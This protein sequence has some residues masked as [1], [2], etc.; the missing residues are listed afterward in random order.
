MRRHPLRNTLV[1]L[2]ILSVTLSFIAVL[3]ATGQE[4]SLIISKLQQLNGM[5]EGEHPCLQHKVNAVIHQIEAGAFHGAINKLQNDV[6]KSIIA[7][8]PNPEELLKLVDEIIDLIKGITPKPRPDFEL[9]A[10]PDQVTIPQGNSSTVTITVFSDKGF[11]KPVTLSVTSPT[12]AGI[13]TAI[14][15]STVTPPPNGA[16]N[17]TLTITIAQNATLT[18]HQITVTGTSNS[19]HHDVQIQ[20]TVVPP[21]PPPTAPN[22]TISTS[23]TELAIMQ[24]SF[25]TF[26]L[27]VTSRNN[28]TQLV[29]VTIVSTSS[30]AAIS[31]DE[32]IASPPK[33][34]SSLTVVRVD[35]ASNAATGNFTITATGTSP[36]LPPRAATIGLRIGAAVHDTTPPVIATV[37]RNPGDPSY[38]ENVTITAFVYDTQ[39]GVKQVQLNYTVDTQSTIVNMIVINGL[40]SAVIPKFAFNTTV[41]YHVTAMDNA[42]NTAT[43]SIFTYTV[44]DPIPP[45]V[46]I[47]AP[48]DGSYLAGEEKIRVT[49]QDAD[50]GGS[51]FG[52]AELSINNT[53]VKTWDAEPSM[54]ADEYTW[55]TSSVADG[56]YSIKLMMTDKAGNNATETITVT[57]DNTLPFALINLPIPGAYLRLSTLIKVTGTDR[58]FDR[59]EVSIDSNVIET[60]GQ[61]G[62]QM[63]EWDTRSYVDGVHSV[64]LTVYDRAGNRRVIIIN[65]T[66]DNTPPE[67]GVPM[68]SPTEPAANE[69]IQINVTVT[70]PAGSSGVLNV[71]LA[72][73][74]KTMDDWKFVPMQFAGG[75]WTAMLTSQ[76]DT[77]VT[78]Y[79]EA[80]DVVGNSDMTAV[81]TFA[82][83][84]PTGLPLAWIL[85]VVAIIAAAVGGTAYY[86]RRR[87]KPPA[88]TAPS[89]STTAT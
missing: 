2:A 58:N 29:N 6:K 49:M 35:V 63:V 83:A 16:I 69:D 24:G 13:N 75:N 14:N 4:K 61:S 39:S 70:E 11:N 79:V 57:V 19:L 7:K 41:Q 47:I 38:T 28:F 45:V 18:T 65:V 22:F 51:G 46:R 59:M 60:L 20:L 55:N 37:L 87:R 21:P 62:L 44:T 43:S 53:I 82:V 34:G 3:P 12:I 31:P 36:S 64:S 23:T 5:L 17:T 73:K 30:G 66:V 81:K 52:T 1:A 33:N 10:T 27:N 42:N 78:F 25:A 67:I 50:T 74:N 26:L 48:S 68:W 54:G 84:A 32:F 15:P 77:N 85:A 72:Y 56:V 9:V 8:V 76:S 40:Y 89:T 88:T 80:F 86:L 71:T